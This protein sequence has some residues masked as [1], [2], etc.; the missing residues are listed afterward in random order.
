MSEFFIIAVCLVAGVIVKRLQ[1]L[2]A[3][4]PFLLNEFII[5]VALPAVILRNLPQISI[6]QDVVFPVLL[7]WFLIAVASIAI[8]ILGKYYAWD[9]QTRACLLLTACLGNTSYLGFPMVHAIFGAEA[10][11]YAIIYDQIGNF[12]PLAVFGSIVIAFASGSDT[13]SVAILKRIFGFPPFIALLLALPLDHAGLTDVLKPLLTILGGFM[14]PLA[15]FLVGLQLTPRVAS[16]YRKPLL[17]GLAI[18]LGFMPLLALFVAVLIYGVPSGT[19]SLPLLAKTTLFEAAVP[20]M[21][22]AGVMAAAAGLAPGLAVAMLGIGLLLALLLLPLWALFL[23][24][25]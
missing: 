3:R 25:L 13:N 18:K 21:V 1:W 16:N 5:Y 2:P 14:M 22:T 15:M 8:L 11:P 4:A 24:I 20:P 7:P 12:V 17:W 9:T 6:N 10:L 19:N 23:Q